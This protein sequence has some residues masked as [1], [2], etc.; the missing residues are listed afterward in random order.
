VEGAWLAQPRWTRVLPRPDRSR[1][2]VGRAWEARMRGKGVAAFCKTRGN[3]L[4]LNSD[5]DLS[6]GYR[7]V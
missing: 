5:C 6:T 3:Y 2:N 7:C 4:L 1:G